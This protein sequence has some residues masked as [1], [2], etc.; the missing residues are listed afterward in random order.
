MY[1]Q[2]CLLSQMPVCLSMSFKGRFIKLEEQELGLFQLI[3]LQGKNN[4][5]I[6]RILACPL[7]PWILRARQW[8]AI[9]LSIGYFAN[10][11]E[12]S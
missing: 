12:L 2:Q 10:V 9:F 7:S 5:N 6:L 4:E 11:E 8:K 1:I 3:G